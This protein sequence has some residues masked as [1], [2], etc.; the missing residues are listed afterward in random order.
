MLGGT[1]DRIHGGHL[2]LLDAAF[3]RAREVGIGLTTASYLARHPKPFGQRIRP[4]EVRRRALVRLLSRRFPG[5]AYW[6]RPLDDPFGGAV[7]PGIDLLV[8]SE[9]TA[10]GAR[11]VN[12][13]RAA[14][15]LP[16]L[17]IVLVPTVRGADG[18]PL[19]GRRIRSG[20]IDAL[21][22]RRRPLRIWIDPGNPGELPTLSKAVAA[23]F[24]GLRLLLRSGARP[25]RKGPR[26]PPAVDYV[27][28]WRPGP[29][30]RATIALEDAEGRVRRLRIPRP[31]ERSLRIGLG[32]LLG[33]RGGRPA[34]RE[35]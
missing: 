26:T 12:R 35:S 7:A 29:L 10:E 13:R 9:E 27:V 16:R 24:P 6:I 1:F 31:G 23:A 8:V 20:E 28:R 5:R 19:A 25:P 32:R 21:G 4:Y 17:K 2:A 18:K 14:R 3:G 15:G 30:T 34:R 33:T 22:R 11:R